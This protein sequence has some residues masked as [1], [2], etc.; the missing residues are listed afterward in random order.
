MKE[1][2]VLTVDVGNT[3]TKAM[4]FSAEGP[5]SELR[6]GPSTADFIKELCASHGAVVLA[7]VVRLDE[8]IVQRLHDTGVLVIDADTP[9]PIATAYT[10]PATLGIDRMC[11]AVGGRA[12][13]PDKDVLVI[14]MGT[15]ITYDLVTA[16]GV[17]LGGAISPG[18]RMRFRALAEHTSKLPLI[19]P[20]DD[21]PV[22]ATD[23]EGSIR[24]GVMNGIS[25]E[26]SAAMGHYMSRFPDLVT[27]LTGGDSER[28]V[29]GLKS[30]IFADPFL[31]LRGLYEI[32]RFQ[33]HAA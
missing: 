31:V 17:H 27:V 22:T 18:M 20:Q 12:S 16:G 14:D 15:C 26:L 33:H 4:L 30:P 7:S 10:T 24:S 32:H 5:V 21:I 19:G 28:F 1:T 23:T 29:S 25:F 6:I 13:H 2:T 11:A 3:Q 8:A 9:K